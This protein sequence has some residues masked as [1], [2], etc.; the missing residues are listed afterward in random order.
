MHS[1]VCVREIDGPLIEQHAPISSVSQ[2]F[3]PWL[4][5]DGAPTVECFHIHVCLGAFLRKSVIYS[6]RVSSSDFGLLSQSRL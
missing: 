6:S 3:V 2:L 4:S 5:L 1:C